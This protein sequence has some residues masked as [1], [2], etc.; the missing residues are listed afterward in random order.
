MDR[1]TWRSNQKLDHNRQIHDTITALE[2]L[3]QQ[4][5]SSRKSRLQSEIHIIANSTSEHAYACKNK[6]VG[7]IYAG[8]RLKIKFLVLDT[9]VESYFESKPG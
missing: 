9:G 3:I 7:F 2:Q 5:F 1:S 4:D 8:N 6:E